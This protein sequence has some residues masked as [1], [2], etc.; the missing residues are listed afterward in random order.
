MTVHEYPPFYNSRGARRLARTRGIP[1]ALEVHHIVGA[2]QA[3]SLAERIGRALSR[4]VVPRSARDASRVR[5]V[6]GNV[7]R[8]LISW[9]VPEAKIT[10]VPSFY[11]DRELF[12]SLEEPSPIYDIAFCARLVANKG[13]EPVLE[14]LVHLGDVRMLV[15]GDGPLRRT[16]EQRARDL[17]VSDRVRFAGWIATPKDV[18]EALRSARVFVMNSL[19]EGGPRSALEAMACGLPVIATRVGVMP[20]VLRDG[21]SGFFTDGTPRDL[22]GKMHLLLRDEQRR[23]AMGEHAK[24]ILERFERSALVRSYADFLREAAGTH[25]S[26]LPNGG[27]L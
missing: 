18:A 9:G 5:T 23:R 24:R 22:A 7:R 17:G 10:V 14:A 26:T 6:N 21:E 20:E 8:E 1:F 13:L 15:I 25:S 3:A 2:P 19:S 27:R 12:T 4:F 11:L 16:F